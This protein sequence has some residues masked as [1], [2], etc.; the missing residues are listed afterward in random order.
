MG[1]L[2]CIHMKYYTVVEMRIYINMEK[3]T[4]NLKKGKL[5]MQSHFSFFQKKGSTEDKFSSYFIEQERCE[6]RLYVI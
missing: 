6:R 1:E 3:D 4:L 5:H 2:G